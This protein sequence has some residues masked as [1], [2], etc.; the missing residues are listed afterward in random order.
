MKN[1]HPE[2]SEAVYHWEKKGNKAK[3]LSKAMDIS[4]AK[5]R[6]A[7]D[8]LKDLAI[9]SHTTVRRSPVDWEELKIILEI[10]KKTPFAFLKQSTIIIIYIIYPIIYKFF[11]AL[12]ITKK[13]KRAVVF[14]CRLF[15]NILKCRDHQWNLPTIWKQNSFR[16]IEEFS[17]YVLEFRSTILYSHHWNTSLWWIK[18]HY[19]LF[20]HTSYRNM[21]L[22]ISSRREN[23]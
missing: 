23:G 3:P 21:Q 14:S 2:P 12:L 10:R 22:Q 13:S 11:K 20:N 18:L 6:V 15:P 8:L 17:L 1:F 5:A 4:S 16:H 19:N 9:L 7:P